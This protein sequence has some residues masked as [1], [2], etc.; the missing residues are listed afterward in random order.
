MD[1]DSAFGGSAHQFGAGIGDAGRAGIGDESERFAI[2]QAL[3]ESR[4]FV[5]VRMLVR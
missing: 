3:R 2:S 4:N 5:G 1:F